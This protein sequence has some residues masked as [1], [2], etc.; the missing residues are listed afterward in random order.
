MVTIMGIRVEEICPNC[1]DVS[2]KN[3]IC[4]QCGYHMDEQKG[5]VESLKPHMILH[6]RYIIGRVLGKGGFGITYK[7]YDLGEQSVCALKEYMPRFIELGRKN[8]GEIVLK[9]EEKRKQYEHGRKRFREEAEILYKIRN[10][11]Y[12]VRIQNNFQENNTDY[13]VM[14]YVDGI[15]LKQ[16]IKDN[17]YRFSENEATEIF[18]KIGSTLQAIYEREGMIHRDISPENILVD[19]RGE[20]KLI[21]F[22]SAKEVDPEGRQGLS[23]VLKP[24]FA[25]LEQYSESMPQG[26]YTDVYALAGTYY[27]LT[28]GKMVPS[29]LERLGGQH[30]YT[31]LYLLNP[32]ISKNVSDAIDRGLEINYRK[33]TQTIRQFLQELTEL[34]YSD[35]EWQNRENIEKRPLRAGT[36]YLEIVEGEFSGKAWTIPDDGKYRIVGRDSNRCHIV[37]PYDSISGTHFEISFDDKKGEFLGRDY[38]RNGMVV[39]EHFI[40][41]AD[42][43]AGDKSVLRFPGTDCKIC[44]RIDD[45]K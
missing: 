26:S 45:G 34:S 43:S 14:E 10:Y 3:G 38:S 33:R 19:K 20:Y 12:V 25:P 9:D 6:A 8:G 40:N 4:T 16:V 42:F 37:L 27:Y 41:H 44:L 30:N 13:Y 18:L 36:G 1:F 31:P 23:V 2:I 7:A 15:N 21:D 5:L 29:A 35:V 24:G 11:P 32:G 17:N 22:G 28:T 39:N